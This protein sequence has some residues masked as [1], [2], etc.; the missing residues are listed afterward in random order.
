MHHRDFLK[1]KFNSCYRELGKHHGI[2]PCALNIIEVV[3][4]SY[5]ALGYIKPFIYTKFKLSNDIYNRLKDVCT[6]EFLSTSEWR[7]G[8]L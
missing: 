8:I 3:V 6:N 1:A 4:D 2:R 7:R 5:P